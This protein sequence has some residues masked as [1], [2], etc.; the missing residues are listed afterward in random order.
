M[1][2]L[3]G[4]E[5]YES[6]IELQPGAHI[7]AHSRKDGKEGKAYL[8][9]NNS[10]TES[11]EVDLPKEAEVYVL[12]AEYVRSETM[13][14]NGRPLVLNEDNTLPDLSGQKVEKGTLTLAPAT[15]TFIVL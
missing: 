2:M 11:T 9:I 10:K 6:G 14:L 3:M 7:F 4:T 8:V 1:W 12:S 13:L 15:C 5:V